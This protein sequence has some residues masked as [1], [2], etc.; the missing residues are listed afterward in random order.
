MFRVAQPQP[1][2][3]R[4]LYDRE[5]LQ[6]A[7]EAT[8]GGVSAY[9]ASR[10]FAVPETTLRDRIKGR[11]DVEAK[12]GHETIFT[13]EE[14]KKLYDHVTYMA[15]IGFGY[16]KK[17]VQYMG[18]DYAESLG[19][20]MKPD[21]KCLSDNWF[22]GFCKR[23]P[24]L[25]SSKPQ[26]LDLS[27]A[28]TSR[29]TLNKYYDELFNVLTENKII[30]KP[31]KIFNID[32]SGVN[33][34][35]TPPKIICKKDTV[36]Q[37]ITSARSSTVTIIAAGNAA[38]Q[39]VP[40]YYV[41]PGQR[42]NDEFLNG[43]CPG[44]AGEMSKSGW[45][46]T[47]VFLNYLTKH[48]IAYVP[49]D[50]EHPTLILY[51]GHRSHISLTLAEW[52]KANN[53][54]LFVLPPHS[55]HVTQPLDVGIFGPFKNIYYQECQHFMKLNPGL[56]ITKY[57]IAQLTAKPYLKALSPEN[58]ISAFKKTGISPYNKLA[59]SDSQI[60][61]STIFD[62]P[63]ITMESTT[64]SE[65]TPNLMQNAGDAKQASEY[66]AVDFFSKKTITQA[67]KPKPK[68]FVPPFKVTGNMMDEKNVQQL[69][70]AANKSAVARDLEVK[71]KDTQKAP[72]PSTSGLSKQ[73]VPILSPEDANS[74]EDIET[75][76]E[77]CCV[78]LPCDDIMSAMRPQRKN[79]K[80]FRR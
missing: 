23:W 57:N 46:N 70:A 5:N 65:G 63:D 41:F 74:D 44:S 45:S 29:E 1:K 10:M 38:G 61:P 71:E 80:N 53:V 28:K 42:W 37:N 35:H 77:S 20:T 24:E 72:I 55:S 75:D 58:L 73:Q 68:R 47:S 64:A 30:D 76:S 79:F 31:Q 62:Q 48:F 49:T 32:E 4:L 3:Q 43:A 15:E 14:E 26:K 40:P 36:P 52:A 33:S 34:E 11:V 59:I 51:D 69:T 66:P 12:V 2:K 22:Y 39:S 8:L 67:V 56:N 13:I 16:T 19:K 27:R 60:A 25:K 9:R 54:I 17:S 6:R 78:L 21:Q 18:R 7:Y 50:S